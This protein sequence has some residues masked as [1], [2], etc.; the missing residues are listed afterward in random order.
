MNKFSDAARRK[1]DEGPANENELARTI[2]DQINQHLST[3]PPQPPI[4][5]DYEG[6][7]VRL[8]KPDTDRQFLITCL[9]DGTFHLNEKSTGF[10]RVM[11]HSMPRT[12]KT[13]IPVNEDKMID[14]VLTWLG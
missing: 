1:A 12:Y 3:H 5:L 6:N 10:Q 4:Q 7:V 8:Y 14:D 13:D 2:Y 9:S 11:T